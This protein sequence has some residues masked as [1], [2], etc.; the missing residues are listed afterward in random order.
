MR[1]IIFRGKRV[2]N[3]EWVEGCYCRAKAMNL[4]GDEHFIMETSVRGGAYS[5]DPETVSQYTG[6]TDKNGVK[7]FEDDIVLV[8]DKTYRVEMVKGCYVIRNFD[9]WDF[10]DTNAK[11]CEVIGNF[12]DDFELFKEIKQ[13]ET[14]EN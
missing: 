1:E 11:S 13:D 7:I 6:F 3:E 14:K 10:L 12:Y 9:D 2:D 5:V 8:G 4:I